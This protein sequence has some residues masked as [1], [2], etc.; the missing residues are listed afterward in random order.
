MFKKQWSAF[1]L[2]FV[3]PVVGVYAW[4]GGFAT[5]HVERTEAGP[6]RYAYLD[7][8]GPLNDMRKTQKQVLMA[9]VDARIVEGDTLTVLLTDP[10]HSAGK[11]RAQVGYTLAASAALPQ[12][13]KEGRIA[14]RL[15]LLTRVQASILLGPSKAYQALSD[16]LKPGGSDISM[17]TVEVFHPAKSISEIG[18]FTLEMNR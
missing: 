8:Q 5:A 14:R 7:Y 1:L 10:R 11:I 9:F 3:L 16:Y 17:P 6:Y 12:G 15:V 2:A 4:W 18:E 13:L